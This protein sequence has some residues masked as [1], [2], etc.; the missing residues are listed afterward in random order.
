MASTT[1]RLPAV[2]LVI[3]QSAC[4]QRDGQSV[5]QQLAASA[6]SETV[7]YRAVRVLDLTGDGRPDSVILTAS[8]H[9]SDSLSV[10][11]VFVVDSGEAYRHTWPSAYELVD[12]D[13][14]D[15]TQASVDRYVRGRLDQILQGVH[16]EPLDTTT[17]LE[18]GD[19]SAL[20]GLKPPPA[21]QVMYA[22]GYE[23]GLWL[24]WDARTKRFVQLRYSD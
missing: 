1:S 23:S 11:L 21:L 5:Q 18:L 10:V 8:G 16:T 4:Q 9:R 22:Y 19:S 17:L 3:A 24:G 6:P 15:T 13:L 7:R 12:P 14:P 20:R 2:L